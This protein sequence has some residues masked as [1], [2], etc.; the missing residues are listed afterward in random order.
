MSYLISIK[1]LRFVM[2]TF[3]KQITTVS[4][5]LNPGQLV[6]LFR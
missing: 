6:Y 5:L 2:N 4:N 3:H 1:S